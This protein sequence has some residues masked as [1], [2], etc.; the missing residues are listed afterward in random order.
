MNIILGASG[1]VGSA[2]ANRLIENNEPVRGI[3]RNP[4][5]ADEL[6][7]NGIEVRVAD[8]FD[9]A[10]LKR[11]VKGGEL[12]F[13][14]TPENGQ[15]KDMLGDTQR[16]LNNYRK[17]IESSGIKKIIGLSSIGAQ[18]ES[19]M[20]NLRMSNMLEN[21]FTDLKI[22]QVFIRP[23]YYFSNWL[24]YLPVVKEQGIL[25]TFF[26]VDQK[27]AMISPMDVAA[28]VANKITGGI[29]R[30]AVYELAGPEK[31]SSKDVANTFGKV[32]DRKVIA[33]QIPRNSWKETLSDAGFTEDAAK[34][35]I[36]MTEA[37]IQE[38]AIP[39]AKGTNP[40]ILKTTLERYFRKRYSQS[41]F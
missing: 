11:T 31:L 23:A 41:A 25:P 1:Q 2:L 6:E 28:F 13:V 24:I 29:E 27:I 3:L 19:G 22:P 12:I 32:L 9:L 10:A 7:K 39:E 40:V 5:K 14:L 8:Y 36:E 35:L 4:E 17:A 21:A 33:Q 16:L 38:K 26:P 30:S 34:N 15:S 20:G 37:V 18:H